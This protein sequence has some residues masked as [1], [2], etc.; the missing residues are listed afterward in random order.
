[1]DIFK[2]PLGRGRLRWD[3]I[4]PVAHQ[5][6]TR[7]RLVEK[8]WATSGDVMDSGKCRVL[9][10]F[11]RGDHLFQGDDGEERRLEPRY[12]T[13]GSLSS[14]ACFDWISNGSTLR[15]AFHHV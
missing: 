4:G 7:R 3:E 12:W 8:C 2:L 9:S 6:L 15:E 10:L 14:V 5:A 11:T 13:A 1:M